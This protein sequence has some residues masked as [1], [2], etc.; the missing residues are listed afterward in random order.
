M[1]TLTTVGT[2]VI[3]KAASAITKGFYKAAS[4][5]M[6]GLRKP[7]LPITYFHIFLVA[8]RNLFLLL[9]VAFGTLL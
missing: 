8:F 9:L 5:R 4:D 6:N 3:L 1:K 7:L 2:P